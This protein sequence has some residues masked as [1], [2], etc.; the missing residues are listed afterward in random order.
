[1]VNLSIT[2]LGAADL[3]WSIWAG[4]VTQDLLSSGYTLP[5]PGEEG[6]WQVW[7]TELLN[8]ADIAA[9]GL[10]DPR[11]YGDRWREWASALIMTVT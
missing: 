6:L 8:N 1:M 10:A 4:S 9:L 7:A 11:S 2:T 5:N 3:E